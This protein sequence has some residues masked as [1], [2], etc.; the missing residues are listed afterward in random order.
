MELTPQLI[1][2]NEKKFWQY[3]NF[4]LE[5]SN[6]IFA[7]RQRIIL[8]LI[9]FFLNTNI[10]GLPGYIDT[11]NPVCGIANYTFDENI[12]KIIYNRFGFSNLKVP[13]I[14]HTAVE[15]LSLMGSIGTIAQ[16]AKSDFDFW[17]CYFSD[18]LDTDDLNLLLEKIRLIEQ[19]CAQNKVEVHFFPMDIKKI[20]NNDFGSAGGESCGS[21]Q[22]LLLKDEYFRSLIMIAGKVP[23]WWVFP[24]QENEKLNITLWEKLKKKDPG[25]EKLFINI[26]NIHQVD[27]KEFFGAALWQLVKSLDSPYKS[28]MKMSL[29]EKYI[30]AGQE[31]VLLSEKLRQTVWAS[32]ISVKKN[33][34]Y[35][36][37]FDTIS[38]YFMNKNIENV[39]EILRKCF[40]LKVQPELSVCASDKKNIKINVMS[41]YCQNWRWDKNKILYL[42]Q[43]HKWTMN[44]LMQFDGELKK[45]M[46]NNYLKLSEA[47]KTRNVSAIISEEDTTIIGRKLISYYVKKPSKVEYFYFSLQ[48]NFFEECINLLDLK[49]RWTV[50][51]VKYVANQKDKFTEGA[52]YSSY[53]LTDVCIWL[54]YNNIYNEW[55]TDLRMLTERKIEFSDAREF[56]ITIQKLL[57]KNSDILKNPKLFL[58]ESFIFKSVVT[59]NFEQDDAIEKTDITFMY[60]TSYSELYIEHYNSYR[61]LYRKIVDLL[62][63]YIKIHY[64]VAFDDFISVYI[65]RGKMNCCLIIK[66]LLE[67]LY[68]FYFK[69]KWIGSE[70][71]IFITFCEGEYLMYSN[72]NVEFE[73]INKNS[74][75]ELFDNLIVYKKQMIYFEYDKNIL[76]A[77]LYS[78]IF[79]KV[80]LERNQLLVLD[81]GRYYLW[82]FFDKFN[83]PTVG[84]VSYS[85]LPQFLFTVKEFV[86]VNCSEDMKIYILK[87]SND[88]YL[89]SDYNDN[90]K[91]DD[92][93]NLKVEFN[94]DIDDDMNNI[95]KYKIIAGDKKFD[96]S[97]KI[98]I[99]EL[100][101]FL[102]VNVQ[103]KYFNIESVNIISEEKEKYQPAVYM[104]IRHKI[105]KMIFMNYKLLMQLRKTE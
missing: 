27:E 4:K 89:L 79:S 67:Q 30:N 24:N 26:G 50:T 101:K 98:Q 82:L 54:A 95:E 51:R 62:N 8:Q 9:P 17:L 32:E 60:K 53:Y 94:Y 102:F 45:Y 87:K 44:E 16:N 97:D 52:I 47:L 105:E 99:V 96:L 64:L 35:V 70:R 86:K 11:K 38:E 42:D 66:R 18:N 59:V 36:L 103:D 100:L 40:Y 1:R 2:E 15:S 83:L 57:K 69:K 68:N 28:F 41:D 43:F 21:A 37:M 65:P 23:L 31:K 73:L 25:L 46:L 81:S 71:K 29:L 5:I 49:D 13:E 90:K 22:A 63:G 39:L 93:F 10:K 80:E 3:N 58:N 12:L 48:D 6:Q 55:Q 61:N 84:A 56:I 72:H 85:K 76:N 75:A 7:E 77:N 34:H 33:D 104:R 78:T 14:K 74:I 19:W 91:Y 88:K 92:V 20:Y